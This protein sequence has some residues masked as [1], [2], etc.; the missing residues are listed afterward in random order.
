M[1]D[2]EDLSELLT[3]TAQGEKCR[4]HGRNCNFGHG[5]RTGRRARD[6]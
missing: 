3:Y 2:D 5:G 4:F 1:I 6:R